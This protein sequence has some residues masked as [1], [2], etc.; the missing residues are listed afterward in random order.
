MGRAGG[1]VGMCC[2]QQSLPCLPCRPEHAWRGVLCCACREE[3]KKRFVE[4]GKQAQR[5]AKKQ[6]RDD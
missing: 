5:A 2:L 1:G 3:R 4:Q 6:R